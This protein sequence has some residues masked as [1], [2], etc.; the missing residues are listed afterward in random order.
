MLVLQQQHILPRE[1]DKVNRRICLM[2]G[3][4]LESCMLGIATGSHALQ[5]KTLE[6]LCRESSSVGPDKQLR[7]DDLILLMPSEDLTSHLCLFQVWSHALRVWFVLD[8]KLVLASVPKSLSFP[9]LFWIHVSCAALQLVSAVFGRMRW[10]FR[11]HSA[12]RRSRLCYHLPLPFQWL[13]NLS[14]Q[15]IW[16]YTRWGIC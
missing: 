1:Q 5:K 16:V 14:F 6:A 15:N 11:S 4:L 10:L 8:K 12:I 9:S 13:P 7:W 2:V 3:T